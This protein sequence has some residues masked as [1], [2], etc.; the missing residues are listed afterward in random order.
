MRYIAVYKLLKTQFVIIVYDSIV[1]YI[2]I[3]LYVVVIFV[4][5]IA[6]VYQN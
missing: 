5:I 1:N 2:R 3:Q 4:I 6:E